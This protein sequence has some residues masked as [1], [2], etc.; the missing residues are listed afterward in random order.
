MRM[1]KTIRFFSASERRYNPKTHSYEGGTT[2]LATIT[3]NVTDLGTNRSVA[4][5]GSLTAGAKVI[6]LMSPAPTGWE[7]LTIGDGKA[8]YRQ[9]T[10][11]DVL[12]S[13]TLIVGEDN[14]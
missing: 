11:R 4:I 7:W 10:A 1:D 8:K 5:L 14:G 12:K 6:R 3:G 9:T 2:T 13:N